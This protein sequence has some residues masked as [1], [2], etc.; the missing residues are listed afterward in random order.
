M[1]IYSKPNFHGLELEQAKIQTVANDA[2]AIITEGQL[3]F[4]NDTKKLYCEVRDFIL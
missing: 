2:A 3:S 1:Q 4:T